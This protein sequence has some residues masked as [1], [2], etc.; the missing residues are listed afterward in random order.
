MC[1][2]ELINFE[3]IRKLANCNEPFVRLCK[4]GCTAFGND[5]HLKCKPMTRSNFVRISDVSYNKNISHLEFNDP[6]SNNKLCEFSKNDK[7][8]ENSYNLN[9]EVSG[10]D[11]KECGNE[12][13]HVSV[14]RF[15][16]VVTCNELDGCVDVYTENGGF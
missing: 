16:N 9:V 11:L 8:C 14:E 3:K 13:E 2:T 12:C 5:P 10:D 1:E 6:N 7:I 4:F 15:G